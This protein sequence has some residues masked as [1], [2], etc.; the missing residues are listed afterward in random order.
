MK[1]NIKENKEVPTKVSTEVE[2]PK[3][4]EQSEKPVDVKENIENDV[5]YCII[6]SGR[7]C[8]AI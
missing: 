6:E 4:I 3:K 7:C 1:Q 2:E 8:G 5:N